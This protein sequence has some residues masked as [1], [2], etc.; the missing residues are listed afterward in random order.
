MAN[1]IE[2]LRSCAVA[3]L[4]SQLA[5]KSDPP[6]DL[7]PEELIDNAFIGGTNDSDLIGV[8][9]TSFDSVAAIT[10]ANALASAY[11]ELASI[12]TTAATVAAIERIDA[13]V[14]ALD[15]RLRFA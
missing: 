13:Q 7:T 14:D 12:E 3:Q 5:A 8:V 6:V 15:S 4:A 2:I 11:Q 1:Q 10:G 9:F